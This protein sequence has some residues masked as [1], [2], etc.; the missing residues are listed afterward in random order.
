M[1]QP[2]TRGQKTRR[3]YHFRPD[4]LRPDIPAQTSEA[5]L[6]TRHPRSDRHVNSAWAFQQAKLRQQQPQTRHPRSG[7]TPTQTEK[8]RTRHPS[9]D[10][11]FKLRPDMHSLRLDIQ[12]KPDSCRSQACKPRLLLTRKPLTRHSSSDS[13]A[14]RP[15]IK[16]QA[17][18]ASSDQTAWDLTSQLRLGSFRRD[19]RVQARKPQSQTRHPRPGASQLRLKSLGTDIQSQTGQSQ[20]QTRHSGFRTCQLR[21]GSL[22]PYIADQTRQPQTEHPNGDQTVSGQ[23]AKTSPDLT[24]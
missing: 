6:Q 23:Q 4:Q 12:N 16:T 3:T 19:F 13:H 22:G 8:P 5:Q 14:L 18:H 21:L 2:R 17:G 24:T 1:G 10:Q 7:R 15:D 11:A 20:P 9:P